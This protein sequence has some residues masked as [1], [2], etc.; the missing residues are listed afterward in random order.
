M[1]H[2]LRAM[3]A[4]TIAAGVV[5]IDSSRHEDTRKVAL[6][7]V[8]IADE[9]LATVEPVPTPAEN[10][11]H[12]PEPPFMGDSLPERTPHLGPFEQWANNRETR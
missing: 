5:R 3:M 8:T 10:S 7:S 6:L 4:A 2:E 12:M 9:I 11:G 1:N